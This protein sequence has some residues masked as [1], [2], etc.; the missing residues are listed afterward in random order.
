M[1][2]ERFIA[3]TTLPFLALMKL[4]STW[5]RR[6]GKGWLAMHGRDPARESMMN[7]DGGVMAPRYE[8]I[9]SS[10]G[11]ITLII[12]ETKAERFW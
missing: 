7:N 1:H 5:R 12:G 9:S 11:E 2:L 6:L 8:S 10:L 4:I 3:P